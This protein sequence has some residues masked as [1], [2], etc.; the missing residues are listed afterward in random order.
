MQ[1]QSP[2]LSSTSSDYRRS[3][4]PGSAAAAAVAAA[5]AAAMYGGGGN[6]LPVTSPL[7]HSGPGV[8]PP[9]SPVSSVLSTST[10]SRL[11]NAISYIVGRFA[12]FSCGTVVGSCMQF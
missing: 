4:A 10:T 9:P 7:P 12:D 3:P 2:T 11:I 5:A 8:M 6:H 1:R